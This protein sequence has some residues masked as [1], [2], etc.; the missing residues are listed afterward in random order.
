MANIRTLVTCH[1]RFYKKFVDKN[2]NTLGMSAS[3][4]VHALHQDC[5][6]STFNKFCNNVTMLHK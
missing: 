1:G 6:N 3:I 4:A 2:S 5:H